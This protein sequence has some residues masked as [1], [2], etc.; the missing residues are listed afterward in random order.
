MNALKTVNYQEAKSVRLWKTGCEDEGVRSICTYLKLN[1]NVGCLELLDNG[2]TS[3]GCEFLARIL[4]PETRSN[5]KLLKLDH[6]SFGSEGVDK[7]AAGLT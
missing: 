4:L 3:L 5:L 6:N 2:I 7:L 1:L